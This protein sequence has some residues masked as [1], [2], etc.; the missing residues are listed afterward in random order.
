MSVADAIRSSTS[1][2]AQIMGF[3]D[4]GMVREGMRADLTIL[5]L[6]TIADRATFFEPHQY[7]DGIEFVLVGGQFVVEDGVPTGALPGKII[8]R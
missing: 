3:K 8:T 2:P 6:E 4:R 7:A 5:D 1:L